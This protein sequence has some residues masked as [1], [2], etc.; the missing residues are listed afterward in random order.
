MLDSSKLHMCG[1]TLCSVFLLFH[2]S[3]QNVEVEK[4]S[5]FAVVNIK[6]A[7]TAAVSTEL[8]FVI[9]LNDLLCIL[10]SRV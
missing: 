2:C 5:H 9:S 6:T 8:N 7:T 4:R 10:S 3:H 1:A